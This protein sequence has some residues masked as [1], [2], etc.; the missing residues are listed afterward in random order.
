M[1]TRLDPLEYLERS[2]KWYLGG[3]RGAMFAPAFPR[4][5]DSFG[6]WDEAYFVDVRL[7][8]LFTILILGEDERP[9]TLRREGR[10]WTP[11]ALTQT[12]TVSG[13]GLRV[14]EDK[15]VT[16]HDTLASR[17]TLHNDGKKTR[18]LHFLLW[19]LQDRAPFRPGV[20]ATSAEETVR[21]GD[22]LA[23]A[24]TVVYGDTPYTDRPAENAGWGERAAPLALRNREQE[25]RHVL[26]VAIGADRAP[27]SFSVNLAERT[28]TAPQ[29]QTSVA[30]EKFRNG[31]LPNEFKPNG[32]ETGEPLSPPS[33]LI[34]H[35]SHLHLCLHYTL[36]VP[37]GESRSI[38]F[39]ATL[40][41][42]KGLALLHLQN[43]LQQ[44]VASVSRTGWQTYFAGVPYFECSDPWIQKYYWYR[45]YG[46]RLLTVDIGGHQVEG[47]EGVRFPHPCVFEGI[48]GFRSHISYS[49]QCHLLEASWKHDKALAF[50]CIEGM[51]AAQEHSG[52]LP[53]HLYLWRPTRGFY[54]ANWGAN[55]LQLYHITG[56]RSFVARVYPDLSRYAEYFERDR[57][58]E[59]SHLYDI[60]D[61]GETGQEY[62]SR[63][64]FVDTSADD[65]Q[66]I[67]LKGVD[68]T[69][70]IYQLQC[71][72]AEMARLLG[73]EEEA[74]VWERK[75]LSTRE[76]VRTRLWDPD[77]QFFLDLDP[78]TGSRS[79]FK[80][81]VG[82]YPFLCNLAS[83]EHLPALTEHLL[84][85]N[86][87]W[88][89]YPVP[90]S[91][92]DDPYFNA[93]GEWKGRRMSCPWNGRVWPMTNSHIAEALAQ[94]ALTLDASLRP[95]AAEF[96][97]RYVKMLF[98]DGDPERP[99]SFEHYNPQT[100][101]PC[102][103]RGI[104]DYQHSWV[105]D[106]IIKY[107]VGLQPTGSD[108]LVLDPLPFEIDRFTMEGIQY[109]GHSIDVTWQT[110]EGYVVIVDGKERSRTLERQRLEIALSG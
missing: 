23:F 78:H 98:F 21:T 17:I 63:Y 19:S 2:D 44:D 95:Q 58:R 62:M 90:A 72:L 42:E 7:E 59:D 76:A 48:G 45:W 54:H 93:E 25:K 106:L 34:S 103:F 84:N 55:A 69:V 33:S 4:F 86:E 5:L 104:D 81:A 1:A 99:N 29:W 8:R 79:P 3:G 60:V 52:Y 110:G 35:P 71:A 10:R 28:D 92:A 43:D 38:Q 53:G 30:P 82:F 39:G 108:T 102:M 41:L 31:L 91:S 32:E 65:W 97:H 61:Q 75:A 16:S 15:I 68:S 77:W 27:D 13:D 101:A 64:L 74:S 50:G 51:F 40:A 36:E 96:I 105:I 20:A 26:H 67:Q 14:R 47:E 18:R 80:A 94:A 9:V 100:G 56:D 109:R 83:K 66:K 12:Y 49:A 24:H 87:F 11:D 37:V 73:N 89:P 22:Y 57:D 46:L 85:P 88:L 107:L 6:F 70:Y